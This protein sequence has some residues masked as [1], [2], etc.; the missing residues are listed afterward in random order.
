MRIA[1]AEIEALQEPLKSAFAFKGSASAR[2]MW[3]TAVRLA[4]EDGFHSLGLANQGILWSDAAAYHRF[5][6]TGGNALM[7]LMSDFACQRACEMDFERPDELLRALLP[8][9]WEYGKRVS[10]LPGLRQTFALNA[11]VALD[12]AAWLLYARHEGIRDFDGLVPAHARAALSARHRQI[13]AIPLITYTASLRD[14]LREVEDGRFFLKIKIGS[15]PEHDGDP[16]KMLAWD[17][18]RLREIHEA[19]RD[20]PCAHSDTGRIP[21]YLDANG[22][23]DTADR[24]L[25]LLD[26]ADHIGAL[27]RILFL[28]EPFPEEMEMDVSRFPVRLAADESAHSAQDVRRRIDMGY[29]A[30]A[31]K[32]I[33]KTMSVSFDMLAVAHE[34]GVPC[35]CADLTVN[36]WMVDLNKNFAARLAAPPGLKVGLLESNGHQYYA[37]WPAMVDSLP[38]PNGAWV[39]PVHGLYSLDGEFYATSGGLFEESP[40]YSSLFDD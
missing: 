22:R 33:A 29:G 18:Q 7:Y 24:L 40:L 11:L 17:Q 14:V 31:L 1:N 9:V 37:R 6:S 25:R 2:P 10:G 12:T 34:R 13:A 30:I 3:N 36:A 32:P 20:V 8:E 19:L 23:Y 5:S 39:R 27:E 28:E 26:F 21:Y 38:H 15:D 35:F 4:S 16:E